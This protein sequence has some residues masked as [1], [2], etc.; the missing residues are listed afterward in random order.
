MFMRRILVLARD[1]GS[2]APVV[3]APFAPSGIPR[4][5]GLRAVRNSALLGIARRLELFAPFGIPRS[6][7]FSPFAP[8]KRCLPFRHRTR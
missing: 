7:R 6:S 5:S 2:L 1:V 3:V 8:F 4:H